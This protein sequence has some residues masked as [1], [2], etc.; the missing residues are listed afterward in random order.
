[1]C[2]MKVTSLRKYRMNVVC[3]GVEKSSGLKVDLW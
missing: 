3:G 2:E 1:M